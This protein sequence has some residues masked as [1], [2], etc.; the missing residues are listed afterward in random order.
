MMRFTFF[1]VYWAKNAS[2]IF[3]VRVNGATVL[4]DIDV[5]ALAGSSFTPVVR[6]ATVV[7]AGATT[8]ISFVTTKDQAIIAAF[9]VGGF[10]TADFW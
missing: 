3:S 4:P 2:R 6:E 5:F 8:T 1:E 10:G 7:A 9:E